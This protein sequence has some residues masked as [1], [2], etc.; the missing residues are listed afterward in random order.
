MAYVT[1][2]PAVR[3]FFIGVTLSPTRY[4]ELSPRY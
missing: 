2:Q 4:L 3:S 1:I